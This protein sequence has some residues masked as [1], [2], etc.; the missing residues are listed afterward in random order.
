MMHMRT[1]QTTFLTFGWISFAFLAVLFGGFLLLSLD[2]VR[3]FT[4]PD[5]VPAYGPTITSS[6]LFFSMLLSILIALTLLGRLVYL[7]R[8]V[9]KPAHH[10]YGFIERVFWQ[11]PPRF[12]RRFASFKL[13]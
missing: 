7:R 2:Q 11:K 13:R 9:R 6:A 12:T 8:N 5:R 10:V 4:G 1:T 3:I